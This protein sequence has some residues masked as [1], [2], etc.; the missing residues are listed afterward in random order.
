MVP[1]NWF[2]HVEV[3][4][5]ALFMGH[6]MLHFTVKRVDLL[7][8]KFNDSIISR[9]GPVNWP[10]RSCDITLSDHFLW[11]YV[12]SVVYSNKSSTVEA[13]NRNIVRAVGEM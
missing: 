1:E 9:N 2:V 10:P 3:Q 8:T 11:E 6:N 12:E 7:K 5:M 4:S 13:L